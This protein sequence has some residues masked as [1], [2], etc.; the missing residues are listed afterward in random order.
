M[1]IATT[2][3]KA[4]RKQQLSVYRIAKDTGLNQS[5]M[6]QFFRGDRDELRLSTVEILLDYL[7]L[8]VRT[9]KPKRK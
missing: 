1:N 5:S 9:K 3:R 7:G 4:A 6:N 2:I 8:E